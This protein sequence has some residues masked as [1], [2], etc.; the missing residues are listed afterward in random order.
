MVSNSFVDALADAIVREL[1]GATSTV[2]SPAAFPE[3]RSPSAAYRFRQAPAFSLGALDD[4]AIEA[5]ASALV[6][7]LAAREDGDELPLD[8]IEI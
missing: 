1:R 6:A 4:R 8:R 2:R 3:R 5:V 7:R